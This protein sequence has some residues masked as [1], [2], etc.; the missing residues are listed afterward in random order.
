MYYLDEQYIVQEYGYTESIGWFQGQTG[1]LKAKANPLSSLAA[2]AYVDQEGIHLRV[3]YQGECNLSPSNCPPVETAK[4]AKTSIIK[5]LAYDGS[6]YT[7]EMQIKDPV[8]GTGLAAVTYAADGFRQIRVYYQTF[9]ELYLKEYC[10][11]N[12]GWF[13][14]EFIGPVGTLSSP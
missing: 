8:E 6:W 13:T 10:H 12:K 14:G 7:G 5:E 2:I 11:N 1:S 3:Y 9:E 4:E